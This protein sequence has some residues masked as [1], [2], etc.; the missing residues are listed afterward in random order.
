MLMIIKLILTSIMVKRMMI[1][2]MIK[3]AMEVLVMTIMRT[4]AVSTYVSGKTGSPCLETI[5][6]FESIHHVVCTELKRFSC[7]KGES[8]GVSRSCAGGM[9]LPMRCCM[10]AR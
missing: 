2:V 5:F 8:G 4:T 1:M 9:T 6:F 7:A 3:M 10:R